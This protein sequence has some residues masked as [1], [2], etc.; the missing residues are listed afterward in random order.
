MLVLALLVA[1]RCLPQQQGEVQV[2]EKGGQAP[3]PVAYLGQQQ[4]EWGFQ[5]QQEG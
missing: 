3:L 4:R 2:E 1:Q 5:V